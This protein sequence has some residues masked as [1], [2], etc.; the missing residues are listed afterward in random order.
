MKTEHEMLKEIMDK[1]KYEMSPYIYDSVDWFYNE[2][3]WSYR[4]VDEREIIFTKEFMD[5]YIKEMYKRYAFDFMDTCFEIELIESHLDN[6]VQ[7]LYNLI[8]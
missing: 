4:W 7:F 8:K 1:I 2:S 3:D 5:L 6:P